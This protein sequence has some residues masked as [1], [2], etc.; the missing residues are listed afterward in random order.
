MNSK[1]LTVLFT[2]SVQSFGMWGGEENRTFMDTADVFVFKVVFGCLFH[3]ILYIM[4][5]EN[6]T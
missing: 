2:T 1:F 3:H 4:G 6:T 5:K